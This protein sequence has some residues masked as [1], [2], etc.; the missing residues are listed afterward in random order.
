MSNIEKLKKAFADALLIDESN[1]TD[2]LVYQSIPE[3]DSVSHMILINEI[4]ST[5]D[6]SI[7]TDDVIDMSSFAKA[8]EILNKYNVEF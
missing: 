1:V 3:W 7:E 6:I 5:F 8:K 4:E 2:L